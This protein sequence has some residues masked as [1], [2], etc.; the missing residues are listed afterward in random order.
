MHLNTGLK[1]ILAGLSGMNRGE[2][3]KYSKMVECLNKLVSEKSLKIDGI[4]VSS[5]MQNAIELWDLMY[6]NRA[7]WLSS[8]QKSAGIPASIASEIARLVTLELKSEVTGDSERAKYINEI[9]KKVLA[10]LRKQVEYGCAKGSMVFKPY[11]SNDGIAVQ[12][13]AAD[14]FYPITFDSNG[15]ITQC[16]FTEQFTRGK[17]IYTRVELHSLSDSGVEVYNFAYMSKTG[18]TLGS[19]VNLKSIKQ[20]EDIEPHGTLQGAS[21]LTIGFFKVP[22]ANNIDPDSPL[23]IS[24]F[25]RA[26]EHIK[27]ADKRYNQIDWE[28]D[29]KEAAIH[30]ATQCL[31]YNKDQDKFEYPG[32]KE[33]LYRNIEYNTGATDKPLIEPYSPDIRDESYFHGYNQQLRRIEFDSGLAYGTLSDVQEVEKTAEEIKSSKQRSYATISDIQQAL[34]RA[35]TDLVD[36][37]N[38]WV[39]AES[40]A[41]DGTYE[42]TFDWD[43]S[44]I[45]D[46][47]LERQ[48]DR[49]DMAAG[50]M[51]PE[52]YR[53]KWYGE[54]LEEALKNLPEVADV[55]I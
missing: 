7:P 38:F 9:Y 52:E 19:E 33:R 17:E 2:T 42:V 37:I 36:A 24:V 49:Q 18:T 51:R 11:P 28:Y 8:S 41:A 15:N 1:E 10:N 20:W 53:S 16:A 4:N 23:G 13:N 27:I 32:G 21:K 25:S 12:Y 14:S 39:S 47:E 40:L 50:I 6:R 46:N 22:L 54:T 29:S 26:T 55:V 44:I 35:L 3:V 5:I 45:T 31:K 43:D 34:Q 30:I 48:Q